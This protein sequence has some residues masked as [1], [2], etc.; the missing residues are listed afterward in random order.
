M[1]D[2]GILLMES[3]QRIFEKYHIDEEM[4]FA[5]PNPL[6]RQGT[7]IWAKM[8]CYHYSPGQVEY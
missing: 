7:E 5:L 4:G 3:P 2:D 6:V 1:E 8:F